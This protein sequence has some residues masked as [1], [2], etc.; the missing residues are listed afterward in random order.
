MTD[1]EKLDK[2]L[3]N[4]NINL[5]DYQKKMM[6]IVINNRGKKYIQVGRQK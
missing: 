1:K 6:L 2:F 5:L 3:N 4:M